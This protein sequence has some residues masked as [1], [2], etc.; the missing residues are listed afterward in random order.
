MSD[1]HATDATAGDAPASGAP[2]TPDPPTPADDGW[3]EEES[4]LSWKLFLGVF[5]ALAVLGIGA[6]ALFG[7]GADDDVAT[8]PSVAPPALGDATV[9]D[10]FDRP[11]TA[12]SL[13]TADTGQPWE[14]LAGTW[15]IVG[16]QAYVATPNA[17]GGRRSLAV[18][19]LGSGNGSVSATASTMANGWGI[20]FRYRGPFDYWMLQASTEFATYNLV[21]VVGGELVPVTQGGIGLAPIAD[22]T[23]VGVEFQGTT[24]SIV[25]DDQV[26]KIFED[27][28]LQNGTKVGMIVPASGASTARWDDF[29]AQAAPP[30]VPGGGAGA[31]GAGANAGGAGGGGAG[32]AG[33]NAGGAGGGGAG[34][35]AG[36]AGGGGG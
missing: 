6:Y 14:A 7:G 36:G 15:G 4:V 9:A 11:D 19:E 3:S 5:V 31:G 32:G 22:G 30:T 26:V 27:P 12:A 21:K 13:G 25:L 18:V 29:T 8:G 23:R 34:A 20:V 24:I 33:G 1:T 35:N 16:Q 10:D 2:S 28:E 17:E